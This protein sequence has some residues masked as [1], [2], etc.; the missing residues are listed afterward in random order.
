MNSNTVPARI[1]IVG[2]STLKLAERFKKLENDMTTRKPRSFLYDDYM[3][4]TM[5]ADEIPARRPVRSYQDLDSF[6]DGGAE[7]VVVS[8]PRGRGA[9]RTA[10]PIYGADGAVYSAPRPAGRQAPQ[11]RTV[12]TV[13]VAGGGGGGGGRGPRRHPAYSL[14]DDEQ[15]RR[16]RFNGGGRPRVREEVIE[17][18]TERIPARRPATRV[19]RRVQPRTQTITRVVK[20]PAFKKQRVV[21]KPVARGRPKKKEDPRAKLGADDLDRELETYMKTSKHPRVTAEEAA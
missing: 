14:L 6:E 5:Y 19:I 3:D 21:S 13:R 10:D 17:Y 2:T 16:G 9:P 12:R 8:R 20:Q 1:V 15:P 11:Q 7:E 4:N 18:V